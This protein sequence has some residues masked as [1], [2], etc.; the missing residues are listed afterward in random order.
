MY[1]SIDIPLFI[2]IEEKGLTKLKWMLK[3]AN[4]QINNPVI[5]TDKG[6]SVHYARIVAKELD[7]PKGNIF[8]V[9]DNT[10]QQVEKAEAFA[11]EKKCDFII[12]VGGGLA[13][14][15]S[16]LASY[17]HGSHFISIPT[18][19]SHDGLS[20]P[21]ASIRVDSKR[22]SLGAAMPMGII[23]DLDIIQKAPARFIHSGIMD[24]LSNLSAIKDWELAYNKGY[25]VTLNGF[26]NAIAYSAA[27]NVLH[28]PDNNIYSKE[29]LHILLNS[30]VLSGIAMEIAGSS[31]PAS[32]AEHSFSHA[33]DYLYPQNNLLHGEKVGI[34]TLIITYMR[35]K[36]DFDS[37]YN[38]YKRYGLIDALRERN[39]D[40]SRIINAMIAA[41]KIRKTRYTILDEKIIRKGTIKRIVEEIFG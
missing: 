34:G 18:L 32:G 2:E 19:P 14:D 35:S 27:D 17:R 10:L 39:V 33:Y 37:M 4:I 31:R 6:K 20:S 22:M 38:C 26:S 1:N 16:K 36:S 24:L 13:L 12:G 25:E 29:F 8:F 7:I 40:S 30:L 3:K 41:K 11:R 28:Y 23:V 5:M 15:I 9:E 21:V